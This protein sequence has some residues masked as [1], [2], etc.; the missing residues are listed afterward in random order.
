[1]NARRILVALLAISLIYGVASALLFLLVYGPFAG[2]EQLGAAVFLAG[3]V[4]IPYALVYVAHRLVSDQISL[5]V[6]VVC[7]VL[8]MIIGGILYSGGFG[9]NDGEY[10]LVFLF[11]PLIQAPLVV[12]AVA[13][14]LWRRRALR[15]AA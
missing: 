3:I 10:S 14:S 9:P 8:I 11:T 7:A 5:R 2:S 15:G 13:V 12:L 6:L 4:A 1:M